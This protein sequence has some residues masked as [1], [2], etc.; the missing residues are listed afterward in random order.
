MTRRGLSLLVVALLGASAV[1]ALAPPG[2]AAPPP[3]VVGPATDVGII[4]GTPANVFNRDVGAS[5]LLGTDMLWVFGDTF[6]TPTQPWNPPADGWRSAT[7]ALSD[8]TSANPM[9]VTEQEDATNTPYQLIPYT[10]AELDYNRQGDPG[11]DRWALWPTVVVPT[12]ATHSIVVYHKYKIA[13]SWD[14]QY[15]GVGLA[16]IGVG[17]TSAQRDFRFDPA[18]GFLFDATAVKYGSSALRV[19]DRVY[20]YGCTWVLVNDACRVIR[21]TA[22]TGSGID[23]SRVGD[24]ANWEAWD[25]SG[26]TSNISAAVPVVSKMTADFSVAWSQALGLYTA[27]S[28][29][30]DGK[31]WIQTAPAPEGPWS[32]A[33][34]IFTMQAPPAACSGCFD[35]AVNQHPEASGN[36]SNLL[37]TYFRPMGGFLGEIR[38]VRVPL[39]LPG[40]PLLD[41][42]VSG[43]RTYSY[44]GSGTGA[45]TVNPPGTGDVQSV[46]GT[47][48][49]PGVNGGDAT[50]AF[51]VGRLWI[52]PIYL[53][54]VRIDDPGA[55]VHLLTPVLFTGVT[56]T[57]AGAAT[58]TNTWIDFSSIPWALYTLHWS[59]TP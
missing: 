3:I 16:T 17:D 39:R 44:T 48:T 21:A 36:G 11:N 56:R 30:L 26:W 41:L 12:D 8:P 58:S 52:F 40:Q 10:Q 22:D 2:G 33:A 53:G 34:H 23:W 51:N 59:L 55:G 49:Y 19:G 31:V 5:G 47:A 18:D 50:A 4:T 37:V 20:L 25:G 45:V 27:L 54:T 46:Q 6:Y 15:Q 32:D 28:Q 43:G 7:F 57:P 35:Y 42:Q 14:F 38:G 13:G 29:T 9:A 1:L 24:P